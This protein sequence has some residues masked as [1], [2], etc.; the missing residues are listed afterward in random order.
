MTQPETKDS[1]V[2]ETPPKKKPG[3]LKRALIISLA[4]VVVLALAATGFVVWTVQRSFPQASGTIE[5]SGLKQ[6]VTVQRDE[7]G[8]PTIT[9]TT[10]D[11]LFYAQGYV[12]AQDRFWEMDFRV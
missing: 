1:P 9:A 7:R 2:P 6:D 12:H 10:S 4:S 5:V 3:R 11:D 8:I